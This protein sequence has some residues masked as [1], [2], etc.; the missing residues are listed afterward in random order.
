MK[1][2]LGD[3]PH[4][5]AGAPEAPG[6]TRGAGLD[7]VQHGHAGALGGRLFGGREAAAAPSHDEEVDVVLARDVSVGNHRGDGGRGR[8]GAQEGAT[9]GEGVVVSPDEGADGDHVVVRR[10][11]VF[12]AEPHEGGA[13]VLYGAGIGGGGAEAFSRD[14]FAAVAE[15]PSAVLVAGVEGVLRH[16]QPVREE[17]REGREHG[18]GALEKTAGGEA[19]DVD[20]QFV[21]RRGDASGQG[22]R[23][24]D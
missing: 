10:S 8:G 12:V 16:G 9:P 24:S 3:A 11:A 20:E 22:G 13:G 6:G 14:R 15:E 17:G 23:A 4:V 18:G 19:G 7:V 2:L 1:E 21:G 5:D